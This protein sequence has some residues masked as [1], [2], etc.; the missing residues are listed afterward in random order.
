MT[1]GCET[2]AAF[3][4]RINRNEITSAVRGKC[5]SRY[6]TNTA[7]WHAPHMSD[8]SVSVLGTETSHMGRRMGIGAYSVPS[9]IANSAPPPPPSFCKLGPR[10]VG[11]CGKPL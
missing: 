7:P 5:M 3:V 1:T 2:P 9:S 11:R 6:S 10:D 4:S 8:A